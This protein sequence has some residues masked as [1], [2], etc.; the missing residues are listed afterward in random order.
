MAEIT[1][2]ELKKLRALESRIVS[3]NETLSEVRAR[4][5]K[6]RAEAT[7]ARRSLRETQ[8]EASK[9]EKQVTELVSENAQMADELE[10]ASRDLAV[11]SDEATSLRVRNDELTGALDAA[12][13]HATETQQKLGQAE[14][15]RAQ[16]EKQLA[17]L[18]EQIEGKEAPELTPEHLSQLLGD[19][20][21]KVGAQ[22]G[23]EIG[24]TQLNLKVGFSGRGGG[25]FVIPTVG[26][27]PATFPELH[28]LNLNLTRS[29]VTLTELQPDERQS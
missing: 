19:F 16:L 13:A 5:D 10:F 15:A 9:L 21:E 2:A 14:Q 24:G 28:E 7:A 27:D 20:V 29:G 18:S 11:I 23:L 8:R 4:R 6:F 25:A 1:A 3:T 22:T 26:V 17:N 12:D